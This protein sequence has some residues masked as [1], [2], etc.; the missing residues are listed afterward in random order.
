MD[1]F[2][3][4][5]VGAGP[6][7]ASCARKIMDT[8]PKLSVMM[9]D[10]REE[11]G[12]PVRCGEG[13]EQAAE[14]YT[15][16]IP[17]RA[18]CKY[19]KGARVYAPNGKFLE[20]D[21]TKMAGG[22]GGYVL[23]RKVFDKWL[24][25]EA[26]KRGAQVQCDTLIT[27]LIVENGWVRGV[28]GINMGKEIE[29]RAKV[30]V[31]STGAE[32]RLGMQSGLKT[33][34]KAQLVDTCVEYEMTNCIADDDFI[35]LMLGSDIAPRGYGWLFCKGDGIVNAGVGVIPSPDPMKTALH[36]QEVFLKKYAHF[37][38][39]KPS[40]LEIKGGIVPVGDLM[41][42]MVTNGFLV[43]GEAAHH[44]NPIHGGGIKEAIVSGQLA[45]GVITEAIGK[46][47]FSKQGLS[48]FN[49]LWW[50][51]RGNHL[52]NVE[53]LR[54]VFEKFSDKD[55]NEL[56]DV[57]TPEDLIDFSRGQKLG[58]LAKLLLR[59]PSLMFLAKKLII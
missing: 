45:G 38:E 23:D 24:A 42:D 9:F 17:K 14:D 19:I 10:R 21:M 55:L 2:D 12:V 26:V 1:E 43:C 15:G 6:A 28:R 48:P 51:V 11:L 59:K 41:K 18:I 4:I 33:F 7:G 20:A 35:H 58:T 52:R 3:V 25:F 31:C 47:D 57:L 29:A 44:V 8:N 5:I 40:I 37:F 54:E 34:C 53:K 22:R 32:S 49:P 46:N 27:D 36:Y 13:L 30:V 39:G 50:E 16:P 56:A